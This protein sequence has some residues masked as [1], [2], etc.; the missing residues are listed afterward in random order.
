MSDIQIIRVTQDNFE[1]LIIGA[2][3]FEVRQK[4]IN[5]K[6]GDIISI[7]EYNEV[8][9]EKTYRF[10]TAEIGV[11]QTIGRFLIFSINIIG[12]VNEKGVYH[13]FDLLNSKI[14]LPKIK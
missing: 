3:T 10:A 4:E 12:Y 14:E 9:N 13:D 11:T 2:K 6:Y 5:I 8:D 7:E 1:D